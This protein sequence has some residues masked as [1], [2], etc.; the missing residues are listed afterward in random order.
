MARYARAMRLLALIGYD[1]DQKRAVIQG[2]C[3]DNGSMNVARL[4]RSA[5]VLAARWIMEQED[6]SALVRGVAP[7]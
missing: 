5:E 4:E 3:R 1:D 7:E 2:A 6:P